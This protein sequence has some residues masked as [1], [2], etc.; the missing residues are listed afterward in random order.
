VTGQGTRQA[1]PRL[2]EPPLLDVEDVIVRYGGVVAVDRARLRVNPGEIVALIGPNGAGK[3]SLFNA[4]SGVV[5]PVGGRIRFRGRDLSGYSTHERAR[6]GMAR[7]FQHVSLY[8]RL[9]VRENLVVSHFMEGRGWLLSSLLAGPTARADRRVAHGRADELLDAIGLRHIAD[10][11][12]ADLPYG[13]QRLVS[14]A[15]A[16][17]VT[18]RLLMLDEPSAGLGPAESAQLGV[19]I[20][21]IR[22]RMGIPV[23]LIEHDMSLVMS[24]SDHVYV[25]DF[26][27]PLAQGTPAEVRADPNVIAAYLGDDAVAA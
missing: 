3:T 25:L 7:T 8:G 9:T 27:L 13:L 20:Q 24:I 21:R 26:G 14:V 11:S 5:K 4:M 23:L 12:C 1:V 22:D 18:P 16:L 2:G 10:R 6:L 19:M 17:A 15:R